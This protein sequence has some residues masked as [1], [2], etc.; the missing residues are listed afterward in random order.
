MSMIKNNCSSRQSSIVYKYF[1]FIFC[2]YSFEHAFPMGPT[3]TASS[4]WKHSNKCY[5]TYNTL[6]ELPYFW[7]VLVSSTFPKLAC[8]TLKL[9]FPLTQV[10]IFRHSFCFPPQV[11][12]N[13]IGGYFSL[14]SRSCKAVQCKSDD[15]QNARKRSPLITLSYF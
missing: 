11:F 1:A 4:N 9:L 13:I 8:R 5:Y 14:A 12:D 15:Q 2:R 3:L 7:L 6:V 10:R